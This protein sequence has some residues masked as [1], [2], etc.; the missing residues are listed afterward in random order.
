MNPT[1]EACAVG[2]YYVFCCAA[3]ADA[4]TGVIYTDLPGEFP[5]CSVQSMRYVFV[6]YAYKPNAILVQPMTSQIDESMV[7]V[8]DK[9]YDYIEERGFKPKL[10]VTDNECSKAVKKY[11][12]KYDVR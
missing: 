5:V 7:A 9:I 3:L 11:M 6:C 4:Q 2:K 10:N 8:Y 12:K 1:Q